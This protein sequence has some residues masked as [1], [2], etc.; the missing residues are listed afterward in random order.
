MKKILSFIVAA[1][2]IL[3]A[4][5]N[6]KEAAAD[7]KPVVKIGAT[8][9]LTGN[10]AVFGESM[11][12]GNRMAIDEINANPDNV[13]RYEILFEDDA[14]MPMR[15]VS[16]VHKFIDYHH[17]DVIFSNFSA[18][19]NAVNPIAEKSKIVTIHRSYGKSATKGKYN[20]NNLPTNERLGSGFIEFIKERNIKNVA[21]FSIQ[22][23]AN[24]TVMDYIMENLAD[25]DIKIEKY[26]TLPSE[27]DFKVIVNKIKAQNP[28]LIM[29]LG[30]APAT[31]IFSKELLTQNVLPTIIGMESYNNSLEMPRFLKEFY[32]LG[33]TDGPPEFVKKYGGRTYAAQYAYDNVYIIAKVYESLG[34]RNGKK[35]TPEEV[36]DEI[37]RIKKFT[38]VVGDMVVDEDG[39]FH[40]EPVLYHIVNGKAIIVKE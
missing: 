4:C 1:V 24:L 18:I 19:A 12:K 26:L 7:G 27:R 3:S 23:E 17:V 29:V 35:P 14:Q 34:K 10:M 15:G 11:Q 22:N 16:N 21:M 5:D 28:D 25:A 33:F 30:F 39:Q 8:L 13:F 20:F 37:H 32:S 2:F 36:V 9:P 31:E 6:K 40:S 38:G